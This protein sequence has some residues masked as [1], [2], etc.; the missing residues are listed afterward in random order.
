M[1]KLFIL[2]SALA[3][4]ATMLASCEPIG[5]TP[6][7]QPQDTIPAELLPL[8][9]SVPVTDNWCST[10]SLLLLFILKTLMRLQ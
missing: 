5:G 1:K 6:E 7:P 4:T 3:F 8:K 9:Q 10:Q 2:F